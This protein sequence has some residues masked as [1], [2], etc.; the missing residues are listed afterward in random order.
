V[1]TGAGDDASVDGADIEYMSELSVAE[2]Q[3]YAELGYRVTDAIEGFPTPVIAAVSGY[4]FGGGCELAL[5][6]D[7]RVAFK[8]AVIGRT[9]VGLGIVPGWGRY[10][11]AL[12]D[13]RRRAS[14]A[15]GLL[16]RADRRRRGPCLW[17]DRGSRCPRG[18][19]RPRWRDGDGAGRTTRLALN[20][21]KEAL[22]QVHESHLTAGL[23]C[24]RCL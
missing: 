2:A 12:A 13:R 17:V 16:R 8:G 19:R 11:A 3:E 15:T 21:A 24:E 4:V 18:A 1:L 6:A 9:E 7:L 14:Q 5:A 10:S 23:R 22:N 20:A